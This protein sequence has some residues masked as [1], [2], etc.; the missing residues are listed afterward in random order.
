MTEK[1]SGS[2]YKRENSS[3][4]WALKASFMILALAVIGAVTWVIFFNDESMRDRTIVE[5]QPQNI[6]ELSTS[7][8]AS[9]EI[10]KVQRETILPTFD[11]VRISRNGTGV[12]AGRAEPHSDVSIYAWEKLVGAAVADRSGEW[13][14]LFDDPLPSGPTELSLKSQLPGLYE[15]YSSDIVIVAVPEREEDRFIEDETNGVVAILTPRAGHGPSRVLQKP[16]RVNISDLTKGLSFDTLD[17]DDAGNAMIAGRATTGARVRIYLDNEF[18]A[19]VDAGEDNMWGH[20]IEKKLTRGEHIIRL[21]QILEGDGVEVRIEQPFTPGWEID[22]SRAKGEVIIRPGNSLWQIARKLY[23]SGF[24][25][26]L[27]F[28]AN[29]SIIKDPDLIYPGQRFV[30]PNS[31]ISN[32]Q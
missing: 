21:D 28:S 9:E 22:S 15:V 16:K 18:L 6:A 29:K 5:N 12:I 2:P 7:D 23:G 1:S 25:Y 14:L 20:T 3:S 26:T 30:L 27:I 32:S 11:V 4:D 8:A 19:E 31:K 13:V 10:Q 17:Y 24:Q